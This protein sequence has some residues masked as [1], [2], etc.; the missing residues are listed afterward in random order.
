MGRYGRPDY[1]QRTPFADI[2]AD[3]PVFVIRG[4]DRAA[5]ATLRAYAREA[6]AAG[7]EPE[8]VASVTAHAEAMEEYQL[9]HGSKVPDLKSE[10]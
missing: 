6:L 8:L 2:A 9:R 7:A 5:P 3:E 10:F 4:R 1:D